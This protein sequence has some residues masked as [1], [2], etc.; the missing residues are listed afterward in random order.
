MTRYIKP[1]LI[2]KLAHSLGKR[3]SPR[4]LA[5]LDDRVAHIVRNDAKLMGHRITL[6]PGDLEAIKGL[7]RKV[8]SRRRR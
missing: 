2:K 8:T 3:V 1:T 6:N 7:N 5:Y 4:Y